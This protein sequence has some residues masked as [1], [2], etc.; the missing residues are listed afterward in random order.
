MYNLQAQLQAQQAQYNYLQ[1]QEDQQQQEFFQVQIGPDGQPQYVPVQQQQSEMQGQEDAQQ[2]QLAEDASPSPDEQVEGQVPEQTESQM[3]YMQ[4]NPE[5][6]FMSN[7]APDDLS[8]EQIIELLQN[9]AD[10][11]QSSGAEMDDQT[12]F[13][14][15][16]EP[17]GQ[18]SQEVQMQLQQILQERMMQQQQQQQFLLQ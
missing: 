3:V 2:E 7:I 1:Q 5:S 9:A 4:Q 15:N 8:T 18:L 12:Q 11:Q 16:G 17:V 14:E 13:D 10:A 6:G